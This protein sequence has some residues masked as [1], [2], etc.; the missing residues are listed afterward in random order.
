MN[1]I[2][3]WSEEALGAER[4]TFW[5]FVNKMNRKVEERTGLQ[6]DLDKIINLAWKEP[7][8]SNARVYAVFDD[9]YMLAAFFMTDTRL[10]DGD[11]NF[12]IPVFY[13]AK[14]HKH[15]AFSIMGEIHDH[16]E[17]EGFGVVSWITNGIYSQIHDF[18]HFQAMSGT[19]VEYAVLSRRLGGE[20][21][22][23]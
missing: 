7:G 18:N 1:I 9:D 5:S 13:V 10:D 14:K 12:I 6:P 21:D 4:G 20:P 15:R 23:A 22:G 19:T 11:A 8:D 17:K 2:R 16:A 3:L